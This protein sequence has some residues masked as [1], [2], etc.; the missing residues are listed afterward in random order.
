[1]T[2]TKPNRPYTSIYGIDKLLLK[3]ARIAAIEAG[4][5]GVGR[6]INEAIAERLQ[7]ETTLKGR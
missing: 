6:W 1:M 4:Y 5:T 7:K 3:K 2:T